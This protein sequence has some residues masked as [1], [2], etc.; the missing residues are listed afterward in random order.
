[1]IT[2]A[3]CKK[4]CILVNRLQVTKKAQVPKQFSC[5]DRKCFDE[6][7]VAIPGLLLANWLVLLILLAGKNSS[8]LATL[9]EVE[10][11]GGER[12]G[13]WTGEGCCTFFK[14]RDGTWASACFCTRLLLLL[15]YT[16]KERTRIPTAGQLCYRSRSQK[17]NYNIKTEVN[18]FYKVHQFEVVL[19]EMVHLPVFLKSAKW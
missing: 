4:Q 16:Q 18:Y 15:P 1:M 9:N 2:K 10:R 13:A 8:D 19:F 12:G 11:G 6:G 7:S 3:P 17:Y 5:R 14:G